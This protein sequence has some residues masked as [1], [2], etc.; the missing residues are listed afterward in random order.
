MRERFGIGRVATMT[1]PS[2]FTSY[3]Y[4]RRDVLRSEDRIIGTWSTATAYAYDANGNRTQLGDLEYAYDFADRPRSV[5]R[6]AAPIITSAS[7]Q[8]FG[9][10]GELVFANGTVQ[11]KTYDARYRM[12]ANKLTAAGAVT[13][14]DY[15]YTTDPAG[16][17]TAI[18]DQVAPGYNRDFGYDDL[19]RL[20]S[21][22]PALPCGAWAATHTMRWA[23]CSPTPSPAGADHSPYSCRNLLAT[24]QTTSYVYDGRGVRVHATPR[25]YVY[26]PELQLFQRRDAVAGTT[27]EI[28]WFNGHPVAQ[29]TPTAQLRYTF[30]DHL[31]TPILQTD[32]TAAL[33]WRA[34]Y[35]PYGNLY[36]LRAGA[37]DDQ[38]LRLPGQELAWV[39]GS[40]TEEN[41]NIFRWYRAGWGRYTQV[42]SLGLAA[43]MN[44]FEY[45]D[46]N[47]VRWSDPFGLIKPVKPK[48]QSW[49]K[50]STQEEEQCR[51]SCKYGMESCMMSRTFRV[52]RAKNGMTVRAW[53]DGPMSCSCEEPDCWDKLKDWAKNMLPDPSPPAHPLPPLI[54]PPIPPLVPIPRP[55]IPGLPPFF[56]N[57]CML[58]PSLCGDG[59]GIA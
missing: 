5:S 39:G 46:A 7:Y 37:R 24:V 59:R 12:T 8:P 58:N 16:N 57:P 40:G 30:T 36:Q 27:E 48:D 26:T 2:G 50:C 17:I 34:E 33:T 32:P 38:P 13:I 25:D 43:G 19:N 4:D 9:P 52:V 51:A 23:T 45:V 31:G 29:T 56:I 1:D 3:T 20:T 41:Y 54:P 15:A 53:V 14:A 35:E 47:P 10:E 22:T 49:R 55:V 44:L 6:G 28:V 21:A 18:H 42:D 11:S